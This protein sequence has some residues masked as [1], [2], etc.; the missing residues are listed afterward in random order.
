MITDQNLKIK[1]DPDLIPVKGESGCP[2]GLNELDKTCCCESKCCWHNCRMENPPTNC[3]TEVNAV[4]VND[5]EKGVLVAQ[6]RSG[7]IC[8][9]SLRK[10]YENES[11]LNTFDITN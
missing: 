4:W 5:T 2:S 8:F 10:S 7:K 11:F 6:V 9:H 1:H 3:L